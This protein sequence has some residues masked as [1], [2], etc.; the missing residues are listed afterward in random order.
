MAIVW[1]AIESCAELILVISGLIV[2]T[3]YTRDIPDYPKRTNSSWFQ[4]CISVG[5]LN[6]GTHDFMCDECSHVCKVADVKVEWISETVR[7]RTKDPVIIND[8]ALL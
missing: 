1:L 5:S 6:G 4:V 3:E 2:R 8:I 7:V